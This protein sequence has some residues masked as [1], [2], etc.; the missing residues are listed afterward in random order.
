MSSGTPTDGRPKKPVEDGQLEAG[1]R[2]N[3]AG[4]GGA[5][6]PNDQ[7]DTA[8]FQLKG[9]VAVRSVEW[10]EA[11]AATIENGIIP[12][13]LSMTDETSERAVP[14]AD[15]EIAELVGLVAEAAV[16]GEPEVIVSHVLSYADNGRTFEAALLRVVAPAARLLG[17]DWENDRRSFYDVTAGLGTLHDA[18]RTLS[19]QHLADPFPGRSILLGTA[20]GETHTFGL[21]IVEHFFRV[22]RWSVDFRPFADKRE[23][24]E[25]VAQHS[26]D[27][28]GLSLSGDGFLEEATQTIGAL[29]AASANRDIRVLVGGDA[30]LRQR[31]LATFVGAD[32]VAKDGEDAVAIANRWLADRPPLQAV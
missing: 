7:T 30:F 25:A 4:H 3:P 13:L 14:D 28:V 23:L 24:T 5:T 1:A 16:S 17:T 18:V 12:K 32:A 9:S 8:Q 6:V 15:P 22:A 11:F 27:V 31:A 21:T 20:P 26:Y 2:P 10:Q 29:R 19:D